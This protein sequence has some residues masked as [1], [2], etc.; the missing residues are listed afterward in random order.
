MFNMERYQ[1]TEVDLESWVKFIWHFE[2]DNA[3]VH[4]KLLPM[5]SIDIILNLADEMVYETA[6]A[7]ITAPKVHVNSLRSQYSFIHQTGK[8]N[9]W[10]ISFY[11]FGLYPFISKPVTTI[12]NHIADLDQLSTPLAEKLSAAVSNDTTQFIIESTLESLKSELQISDKCLQRTKII[13]EFLE[14]DEEVSIHSFCLD[15]GIGQRTFERFVLSMTGY[16]PVGLRRIR[17]YQVTS[18]QLLHEKDARITDIAY[19]NNYTDQAHFIKEAFPECRR[20]NFSRRRTLSWR[21]RV[22]PDSVVFLQ[23]FLFGFYY[24]E[25]KQEV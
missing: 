9:V 19:D 16:S 12:R 3:H 13:K 11:A 8:V 15:Q 5:D 21:I 23:Y 20:E 10:G 4:H 17:R 24:T 25:E 14:M 1:V 2:A 22:L 18:K 7:R 6:S